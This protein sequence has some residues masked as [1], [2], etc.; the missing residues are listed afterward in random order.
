M[1]HIIQY[2]TK[3][4]KFD[5]ANHVAYA[6][7]LLARSAPERYYQ[8]HLLNLFLIL[9]IDNQFYIALIIV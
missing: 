7:M 1:Y 3:R 5:I 4:P 6:T 8:T 2:D 9:F